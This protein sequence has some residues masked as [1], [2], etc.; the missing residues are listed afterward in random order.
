MSILRPYEHQIL[1]SK[2]SQ[3]LRADIVLTAIS[4][5]N[6]KRNCWFCRA[7]VT[8]FGSQHDSLKASW[9]PD[10]SQQDNPRFSQGWHGEQRI[11]ILDRPVAS[12][13]LQETK[14]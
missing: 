13:K 3:A 9:S 7:N 14:I 12:Q 4:R 6:A 8:S 5:V 10:I 11:L 1:A 2:A